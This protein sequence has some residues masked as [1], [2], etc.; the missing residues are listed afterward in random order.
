MGIDVKEVEEGEKH[1]PKAEC[2]IMILRRLDGQGIDII[3]IPDENKDVA[4][5]ATPDDITSLISTAQMHMIANLTVDKILRFN[6]RAKGM[7]R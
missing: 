2:G 6:K 1:E 3:P 4:R 5:G 7:V